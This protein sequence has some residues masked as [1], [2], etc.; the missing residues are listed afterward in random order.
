MCENESFV[1]VRRVR[2]RA[3]G[4]RSALSAAT[5]IQDVLPSLMRVD[6]A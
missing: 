5:T 6:S 2:V 1:V 4:R 3:L